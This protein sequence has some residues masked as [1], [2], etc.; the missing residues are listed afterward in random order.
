VL[1]AEGPCFLSLKDMSEFKRQK[2][3]KGYEYDPGSV[4]QL[5]AEELKEIAEYRRIFR[6]P[7]PP[8]VDEKQS[9]LLTKPY[10]SLDETDK[11]DVLLQDLSDRRAAEYTHRKYLE[12]RALY[13]AAL[14]V[15][16]DLKTFHNDDERL[17]RYY[18]MRLNKAEPAPVGIERKSL[19]L[20][21]Q[22][23]KQT[24]PETLADFPGRIYKQMKGKQEEIDS[25]QQTRQKY[26]DISSRPP[27]DEIR[28]VVPNAMWLA[29]IGSDD[30]MALYQ[31]QVIDDIARLQWG[32]VRSQSSQLVYGQLAVRLV[33]F[34][35][36]L[37]LRNTWDELTSTR[38]TPSLAFPVFTTRDFPEK[39]GRSDIINRKNRIARRFQNIV[40]D[41]QKLHS[42]CKQGDPGAFYTKD[43]G[44]PIDGF[45]VDI[46]QF[47]GLVNGLQH[48]VGITEVE[49]LDAVFDRPQNMHKFCY[50]AFHD[51]QGLQNTPEELM[52][53]I[54]AT[55]AVY[56]NEVR[57]EKEAKELLQRLVEMDYRHSHRMDSP[58][59]KTFG[60]LARMTLYQRTRAL[61]ADID[62]SYKKPKNDTDRKDKEAALCTAFREAHG[63]NLVPS[64]LKDDIMNL[65]RPDR[66]HTAA[67]YKFFKFLF[68]D[69]AP[70][71]IQPFTDALYERYIA[72]CEGKTLPLQH[73]LFLLP[74][75]H[76]MTGE[77][78][79]APLNQDAEVEQ[80]LE[81]ERLSKSLSI[82]PD[83]PAIHPLVLFLSTLLGG[84]QYWKQRVWVCHIPRPTPMTENIIERLVSLLHFAFSMANDQNFLPFGTVNHRGDLLKPSVEV[85]WDDLN[86]KPNVDFC[87]WFN[88]QTDSVLAIS[89]GP[90]FIKMEPYWSIQENLQLRDGRV[91]RSILYKHP[92]RK[93]VDITLGLG[94]GKLEVQKSKIDEGKA[95]SIQLPIQRKQDP[96]RE[97]I[98]QFLAGHARPASC[99]CGRPILYKCVKCGEGFCAVDCWSVGLH[100]VKC[101]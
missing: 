69:R 84:S 94:S 4:E 64:E 80:T 68:C 45:L 99:A 63:R 12:L 83:S 61:L 76:F 27:I 57:S 35:R 77:D 23:L 49:I 26:A 82:V 93:E 74:N 79:T 66:Q 86:R 53:N 37:S 89:G 62:E 25:L 33:P 46:A 17:V 10:D 30:D 95:R 39:K 67:D 11:R 72:S 88:M 73:R 21:L 97:T 87:T 91:V 8:A 70:P 44:R 34:N 43:A 6:V 7:K 18:F 22:V 85:T 24:S 92:E 96:I 47:T 42:L 71:S 48:E 31:G 59:L 52:E 98:K 100:R 28:S 78:L 40:A 58:M 32:N 20:K 90:R 14:T 65:F 2:T 81:A 29:M 38:F 75:V 56:T 60:K 54:G 101:A 13:L 3:E 19:E 16:E 50:Y 9:I 41:F 15:V 1:F 51:M 36:V 55:Y 5:T